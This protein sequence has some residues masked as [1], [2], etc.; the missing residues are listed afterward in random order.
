[1]ILSTHRI[2]SFE[3]FD[4]SQESK[5]KKKKI[6]TKYSQAISLAKY[7]NG[8]SFMYAFI[9]VYERMNLDLMGSCQKPRITRNYCVRQTYK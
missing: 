2:A 1:M 8:E 5:K 6:N 7:E 4:F 9:A 3:I